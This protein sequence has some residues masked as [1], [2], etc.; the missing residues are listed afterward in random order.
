MEENPKDDSQTLKA[1]KKVKR[2]NS[3]KPVRLPANGY[4]SKTKTTFRMEDA[5]AI[6]IQATPKDIWAFLTNAEDFPRWNSTVNNIEGVI[7][8]G[9]KIKLHA[10][11]A[12]ER[13]FKLKVSE[14]ISEKRMVWRD[15]MAPMFTGVRTYTLTPR[16]DGSTDFFM[17]EIFSG[18]MLPLIVRSLPDFGPT[19]ERYAA[20]LKYEAEQ[21]SQQN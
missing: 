14:F 21:T 5:V 17:S 3:L 18:I 10:E 2:A 7:A 11:I 1:S 16:N 20:D 15:G 8:L 9:E 19:F 6:N 13:V 12:P 4:A